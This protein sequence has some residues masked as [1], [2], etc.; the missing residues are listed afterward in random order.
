MYSWFALD[1]QG[2]NVKKKVAM[3]NQCLKRANRL[4]AWW[5]SKITRKYM[6]PSLQPAPRHFKGGSLKACGIAH[7]QIIQNC[8]QCQNK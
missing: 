7:S 1:S 5:R 3:G 4:I 6:L 8:R 2:A